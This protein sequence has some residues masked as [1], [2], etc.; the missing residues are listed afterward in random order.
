MRRE[1]GRAT[2]KNT[3]N[4]FGDAEVAER[5]HRARPLYQ[6]TVMQWICDATGRPRF[7]RALDVGCGSGHS[8]LALTEI[9]DDVVGLDTSPGMLEQAPAGAGIRYQF[10]RAEDLKFDAAEFELVTV[11]S[12]LHWFVQDRF[13]AECQRVLAP[14]GVLVVY[15][16]H[17]TAHMQGS[18]ECKRW[19]RTR[20]A[21]RFPPPRRGMRDIDEN[22]AV[23]G[24]F[25]VARRGSFTHLVS[26]TRDEFIAYLL[27]RSNTLAVV[28][29]GRESLESI[30]NWLDEEL[31]TIVPQNACGEF[32]FKCNL[33][34]LNRPDSDCPIQ[35]DKILV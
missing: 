21:K 34:L 4:Y 29:S 19:M 31:T 33:W 15:N 10:G 27:T 22:K 30:A 5:Y 16:D 17:F 2:P 1:Q 28:D 3:P 24:G 11:G 26:Y 25:V 20:F 7:A 23:Q 18:V 8:T 32:I 35:A 13:Y 14:G 6:E 12:A 9:S